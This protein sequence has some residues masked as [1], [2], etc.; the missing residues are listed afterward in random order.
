MNDKI[1]HAN[2]YTTLTPNQVSTAHDIALIGWDE[3]AHMP[4]DV[5]ALIRAG[6]IESEDYDYVTTDLYDEL[7]AMGEL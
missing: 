5:T 2:D 6:L 4:G 1:S 3:D 7:C